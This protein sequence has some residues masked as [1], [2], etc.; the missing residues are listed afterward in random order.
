MNKQIL[1]ETRVTTQTLSTIYPASARGTPGLRAL[2]AARIASHPSLTP[3]WP[4]RPHHL[5]GHTPKGVATPAAARQA[6]P[7]SHPPHGAARSRSV[8]PGTE[9]SV[10]TANIAREQPPQPLRTYLAQC[11]PT[12]HP[13]PLPTPT[14]PRQHTVT[15]RTAP[16]TARAARAGR[17][18]RYIL[19]LFKA[20]IQHNHTLLEAV[21]P[22]TSVSSLPMFYYH[23]RTHARFAQ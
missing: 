19:S 14:P 4:L 2:C 16:P 8:A 22:R 11:S 15:V 20:L 6:S 17:I 10:G 21:R 1:K 3:G 7:P 5:S 9:V 18:T 12:T 23:A 13:P